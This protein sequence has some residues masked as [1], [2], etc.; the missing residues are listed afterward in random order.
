MALYK[1]VIGYSYQGQPMA[2]ILYYRDTGSDVGIN[3]VLAQQ[4][5][6]QAIKD[7]VVLGGVVGQTRLGDILPTE[8]ILD[9][10]RC[11][12]IDAV[13]FRPVTN[14]PSIVNIGLPGLFGDDA[15]SP[16]LCAILRLIC[17]ASTVLPTDYTPSGGYLAIGPVPKNAA[18]PAGELTLT[19]Q[20]YYN[21]L[22][23]AILQVQ[24]MGG[25]FTATP[26]RIG[27][28]K[29]SLNIVVNGFNDVQSV[30]VNPKVSFRRSRNNQ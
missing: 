16:G 1:A 24:D 12:R 9:E 23:A 26:I 21:N 10:V 13:T 6:A 17:P 5:L 15:M 28:G 20:G 18:N 22:S 19:Q 29:N 25:G 27:R 2:N 8:A 11:Q 14:A 7:N 4:N 3:G 30:S